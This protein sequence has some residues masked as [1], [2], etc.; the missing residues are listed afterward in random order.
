MIELSN[1]LVRLGHSVTIYSETGD[2]ITW[3]PYAGQV[4]TLAD[5]AA[6]HDDVLVLLS[7][8]KR[9][10]LSAFMACQPRLRA[11]CVMGFDPTLQLRDMLTDRDSSTLYDPVVM[12][13]A[14]HLPGAVVLADSSWQV[15]WLTQNVGVDCGPPIGGVNL[16]Q[17]KPTGVRLATPP[18]RILATGDPRKRKGSETV[19]RAFERIN[20]KKVQAELITYWGKRLPQDEMA[21]WYSDGDVFVDAEK[22]AGWCNPVAEAMACGTACVSTDIG[23]VHDFAVHNETALLVP[24]DD[25]RAMADAIV[26]LLANKNLRE[27]LAANGLER[28]KAFDYAIIAGRVAAYLEA[29][30][31]C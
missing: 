24:V 1:S 21:A 4:G 2:P 19:Q 30:L 14:L 3:L 15:E 17:F 8:W 5:A 6:A 7:D 18:Y 16:E 29:R 11:V 13:E 31:S 26:R 20:Q 25:D 27:R 10:W 28:I 12:R 9:K 23:A 22:R